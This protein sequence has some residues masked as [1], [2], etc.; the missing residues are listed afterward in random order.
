MQIFGR[1]VSSIFK[2]IDHLIFCLLRQFTS[3]SPIEV[4]VEA[5]KIIEIS[6]D[7][8]KQIPEPPVWKGSNIAA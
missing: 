1:L 5:W 3:E 6:E 7:Y 2:S 4:L 8:R